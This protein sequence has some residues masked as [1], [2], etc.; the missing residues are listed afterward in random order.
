MKKLEQA[1]AYFEDAI[2][3][4]DEI[5]AECSEALQKELTEQKGHFE[6]ALEA[7]KRQKQQENEQLL[8]RVAR[9][10]EALIIANNYMPDVGHFC[11]CGKCKK[12][13]TDI[14]YA[15]YGYCLKCAR[16]IIDAALS[17]KY[18]DSGLSPDEVQ[19][20]AKA[21]ADGRL[22]VLPCKTEDTVFIEGEVVID[23]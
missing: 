23:G 9:V 14:N 7:M 8:A 13:G 12:C 20:L 4:S 16:D 17:A 19:E 5:I 18:E 6:V 21:K 11:T 2:R 15:G 3:E 10:R 22:V 1:I